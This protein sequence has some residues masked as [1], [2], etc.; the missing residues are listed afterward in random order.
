MASTNPPATRQTKQRQAVVAAL[1][2]QSG[3]KSAQQIHAL[4]TANGE[5]IGLS[6]VYRNLSLLADHGLIDVHLRQDGESVFK[7]C[8]ERHHH[9]L[10]CRDC[11]KSVEISAEEVE[12]W[13]RAVA[14]R[15]NFRELAHS[16]ELSGICGDCAS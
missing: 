14:K 12:Q 4:L 3:F 6:T 16:I 8:S 15:H 1:A 7:K 2:G 10:V 5:R 9:H 13:T 11:G